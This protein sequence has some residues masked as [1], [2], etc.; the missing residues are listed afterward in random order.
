MGVE[1]TGRAWWIGEQVN[2]LSS[3]LWEVLKWSILLRANSM[4]R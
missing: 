4:I 1:K 2:R 3:G